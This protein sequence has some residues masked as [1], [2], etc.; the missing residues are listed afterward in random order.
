L[1][2]K[3]AL[4][5]TNHQDGARRFGDDLFGRRAPQRTCELS[6]TTDNCDEIAAEIQRRL[7]NLRYRFTRNDNRLNFD[8]PKEWIS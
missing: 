5:W 1:L 4:L 2:N 7:R 6:T 3:F 8:T